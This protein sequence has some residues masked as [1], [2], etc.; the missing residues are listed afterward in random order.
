[1]EWR[2][3][4]FGA[5]GGRELHDLFELR[6]NVFVVE[7]A[8]AYADIDGHDL[9]AW[10]LSGR[11]PGQRLLAYARLLGPGTRFAEPSIGRVVTHPLARRC[12]LGRALM[13][14]ALLECERHYPGHPIRISAQTYLT[15]FYGELGFAPAGESYDED[16][17]P[18]QDM[19]RG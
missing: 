18:H 13:G 6:Q 15:A 19:I 8:C 2:C 10:H 9:E 16:G 3:V 1:M 12:G 5:L 14:R 11:D 7:Q 17:I 4:R